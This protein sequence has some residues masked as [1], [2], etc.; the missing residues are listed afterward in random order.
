MVENVINKLKGFSL[1]SLF[2]FGSF[3]FVPSDGFQVKQIVDE[4]K[5]LYPGQYWAPS[6][7]LKEGTT[8]NIEIVV[9]S[10]PAVNFYVMDES[11]YEEFE[12]GNFQG[13]EYY[14]SPSSQQTKEYSTEFTIPKDANFY[15]VIL[16]TTMTSNTDVHL[17]IE[18][19]TSI[20]IPILLGAIAIVVVGGVV[21]Y[22]KKRKSTEESKEQT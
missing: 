11:N 12:A 5:T 17:L 7:S 16:T 3:L 8:V 4:T 19:K 14:Q 13:V 1:I 21:W 9:E 15:F 18:K 6:A 2:F 20:W 22:F 10:G